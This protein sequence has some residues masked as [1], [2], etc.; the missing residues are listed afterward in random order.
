MMKTQA[1]GFWSYMATII[2]LNGRRYYTYSNDHPPAHVHV[3]TASGRAKFVI[4]CPGGPVR[5]VKSA[6]GFSDPE[7]NAI[8]KEI[9]EMLSKCCQHWKDHHGAFI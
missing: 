1:V 5:C 2:N 8:K 9:A 4:N 6:R 7:L 3:S